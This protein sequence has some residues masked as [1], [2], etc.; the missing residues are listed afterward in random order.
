MEVYDFSD[1]V[2]MLKAVSCHTI[3]VSK[4]FTS[5]RPG[6]NEGLGNEIGLNEWK[7]DAYFLLELLSKRSL[8]YF[9]NDA[10]QQ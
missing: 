6:K 1:L 2:R 7:N 8:S 3:L 4:H 9:I 10:K 5:A